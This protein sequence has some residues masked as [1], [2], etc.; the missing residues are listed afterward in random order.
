MGN[1]RY[2]NVA[3]RGELA[4]KRIHKST[5][6]GDPE[7]HGRL[8]DEDVVMGPIDGGQDSVDVFEP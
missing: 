1:A 2:V 8:D 4:T 6:L 7:T 5:R 3:Q